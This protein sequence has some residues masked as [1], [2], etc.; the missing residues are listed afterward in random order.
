[1]R[2]A[3]ELNDAEGYSVAFL[4]L[5][6]MVAA[7][8]VSGRWARSRGWGT[9]ARWILGIL[10]MAIG[11]GLSFVASIILLL[12]GSWPGVMLGAAVGVALL[13]FR[14]RMLSLVQIASLQLTS[15]LRRW[16]GFDEKLGTPSKDRSSNV[17]RPWRGSQRTEG[18]VAPADKHAPLEVSFRYIDANGNRSDRRVTAM[19][20]EESKVDA[21]CHLRGA[22]RSFRYDRIVGDVL[23]IETGELIPVFE[24]RDRCLDQADL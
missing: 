1:M 23:D 2:G 10:A 17:S 22:E 24:W 15:L 18:N 19:W 3:G 6:G 8:I 9:A 14:E 5:G 21:F 4:L 11:L 12:I 7:W 16:P 20:F 13:F